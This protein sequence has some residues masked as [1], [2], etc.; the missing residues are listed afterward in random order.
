MKK[1]TECIT[2]QFVSEAGEE[3]KSVHLM[4]SFGVYLAA[5]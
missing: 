5:F 4:F 3:H 1:Q 2:A